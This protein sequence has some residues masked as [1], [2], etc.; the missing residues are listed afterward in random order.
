[1][2]FEILQESQENIC[3]R[4]YF[5]T[6]LKKSLR[7]RCFPVNF[8]KFLRTPLFTEHFRWLLLEMYG[9]ESWRRWNLFKQVIIF[10]LTLLF[11]FLKKCIPLVIWLKPLV[12][13][14][15]SLYPKYHFILSFIVF[16]WNSHEK[17]D[18]NYFEWVWY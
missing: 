6:K 13:N 1:M 3:A 14:I 8:V 11:H 15:R 5:L 7:H 2:L 10:V 9:K 18:F 16:V 4:D 12:P 17:G